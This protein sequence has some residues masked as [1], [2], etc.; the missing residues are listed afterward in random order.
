MSDSPYQGFGR[1]G[2]GWG[3]GWGQH[4]PMFFPFFPLVAIFFLV[5]IVHTGLW[6]PL[7]VVG[8]FLW[9]KASMHRGHGWHRHGAPPFMRGQGWPHHGASPFGR[10]HGDR[11]SQ[12][13]G[14][15]PF[16]G[17]GDYPEKPKRE[18]DYSDKPKRDDDYI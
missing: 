9:M 7:L 3:H 11:G 12:R 4:R 6:L 15:N 16:G 13:W 10:W 2:Q 14:H 8:A 1:G 18:G 5:L 17:E